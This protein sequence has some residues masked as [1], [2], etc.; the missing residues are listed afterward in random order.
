MSQDIPRVFRAAAL[1]VALAAT[2]VTAEAQGRR[3]SAAAVSPWKVGQSVLVSWTGS[4]YPAKILAV[5]GDR[6]RIRYDGYDARWDEWVPAS[7]MRAV[8]QPKTSPAARGAGS[9]SPAGHYTC[10]TFVS[11]QLNNV[12]EFVLAANGSYQDRWNKGS[13]RYTYDAKT[14]RIRFTSGPQRNDRA[15]VTFDPTAG[16][17]RRGWVQFTYPGGAKLHC[18]R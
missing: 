10:Q 12:G 6:Y 14:R 2:A 8:A 7:R 18:Y 5:N 11:G 9:A 15:V 17:G 1:L 3:S 4:W 13:G 16:R